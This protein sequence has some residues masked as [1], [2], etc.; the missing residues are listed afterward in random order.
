M[1]KMG[2]LP[3]F[4]ITKNRALE[5]RKIEMAQ[6]ILLQTN[7][8]G[9]YWNKAKTA[10]Y[11]E[12]VRYTDLPDWV[13][14]ANRCP[15]AGLGIYI[16]GK[17][18]DY[19]QERFVYIRI[20]GMSYDPGTGNPSFAFD[21][22]RPS[23][24]NSETM[25]NRLP[26]EN[27]HLISTMQTDD[28][29]TVLAELGENVPDDWLT[30]AQDKRPVQVTWHD[31]LGTFFLALEQSMSDN[32][33]EDRIASLLTA[34]GFKVTQKGHTIR[35]PYADGVA[36][37]DDV[38]IVYDCKNTQNFAP[39]E[40]DLRAL[41]QYNADE[42]ILQSSKTLYSA[43]VSRDFRASTQQDIFLVRVV[44]LLYL[45]YVKLSMGSDFNLNPLKLILQKGEG[46]T[47]Q[48]ID[49]HWRSQ[50]SL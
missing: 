12:Q 29:L 16:R 9:D 21:V 33:F 23:A 50:R 40:D 47:C 38:G 2:R 48:K 39:T 22:I 45:L 17:Q 25:R 14:L 11:T 35:G 28:L 31:W 26:Y 30:L 36:I 20:T 43:F 19:S 1:R 18:R 42:R 34:I 24:T 27:R 15:L 8:A 46:L 7:W 10:P 49:E 6:V 13:D 5:E 4:R 32:D 37:Y 41:R 44:S 3:T